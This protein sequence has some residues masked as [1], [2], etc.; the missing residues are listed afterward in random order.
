MEHWIQKVSL[1]H[2]SK[3]GSFKIR[4]QLPVEA[5]LELPH[6]PSRFLSIGFCFCFCFVK[7]IF[8]TEW[9]ASLIKQSMQRCCASFKFRRTINLSSSSF[10]SNKCTHIHTEMWGCVYIYLST[11]TSGKHIYM[12]RLVCHICAYLT[13]RFSLISLWIPENN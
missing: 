2:S 13:H 6:C 3:V 7:L 9:M 8:L 11:Y 10:L 12:H 4:G 5:G 1:P